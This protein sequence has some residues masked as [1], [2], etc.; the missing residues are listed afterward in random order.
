[1]WWERGKGKGHSQDV[2]SWWSEAEDSLSFPLDCAFCLPLYFTDT[3]F[4]EL[5]CYHLLLLTLV[6]NRLCFHC[7]L[8]T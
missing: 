3:V 7:D 5:S 4:I 1:M 8:A 2:I 6:P